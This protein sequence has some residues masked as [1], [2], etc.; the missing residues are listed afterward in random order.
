MKPT[1]NEALRP[2]NWNIVEG[3]PGIE[4][5]IRMQRGANYELLGLS[6]GTIEGLVFA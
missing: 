6:S 5:G 3:Y 1:H 2:T 4:E